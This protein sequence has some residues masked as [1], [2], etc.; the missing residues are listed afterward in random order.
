MTAP[1]AGQ[2]QPPASLTNGRRVGRIKLSLPKDPAFIAAVRLT[3]AGVALHAGLTFET[4]E[5][6]KIIAAEACTYC[7]TRGANPG[8]LSVTL[9]ARPGAFVIAVSDPHFQPT[10]AAT[11]SSLVEDQGADELFLLRGLADELEYRTNSGTGLFLR[12]V[13]N[14]R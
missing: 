5:D 13:K 14:T 10:S 9:E 3:V 11:G 6:L 1:R 2:P 7:M 8:R 12:I 4:I